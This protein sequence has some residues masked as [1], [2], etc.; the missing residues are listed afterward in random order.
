MQTFGAEIKV[1][2]LEGSLLDYWVGRAEGYEFID[3][4]PDVNGEN[5]SRILA[6]PGLF[7]SGW[8]PMP[9]GR[10]GHILRPWSSRW[11]DAGPIIERNG[12]G[13]T[14]WFEGSWCAAIDLNAHTQYDGGVLDGKG[15]QTGPTPL[16]A[17]M[18]AYVASKFGEE[19]PDE[20][21]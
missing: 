16:I 19:V 8:V 6:P 4:P 15:F 11:E 18:R 12:I 13:M 1:S 10:Y 17:A 5:A 20:A 3:I 14:T 2:D 9:K 21:A 7:Q